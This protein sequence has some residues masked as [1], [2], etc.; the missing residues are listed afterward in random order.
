MKATKKSKSNTRKFKI[1]ISLIFATA[2]FGLIFISRKKHPE[3]EWFKFVLAKDMGV[4][5]AANIGKII[6]DAPAG[7][8]GFVTTRDKNFYFQDG[9]PIKFWGTNLCFSA[10]FPTKRQAIMLAK[11]LAFFGFNAVRLHHMDK[12]FSPDGIFKD[13]CP[14]CDNYQAKQTGVLDASQLDRLD[15]LIYQL[16]DRGIY[17]DLN[18]LVSRRFTLADGVKDAEKLEKAGKPVSM[19]D[20]TLIEL[21]KNYAKDLLTHY[22]PYTKLH[23]NEEPAIALVEITN[24]NS[25]FYFDQKLMPYYYIKEFDYF[26]ENFPKE[27]HESLKE[28]RGKFFVYLERKYFDEMIDFLRKECKVKVPIT[29]I[30]G[31]NQKENLLSMKNCSFFDVHSYWDHPQFPN[32][33][34]D[35]NDFQIH[36]KSM[37]LDKGLGIIDDLQRLQPNIN[38]PFTISE[39]DHCYPNQYAYEAMP[40][41]AYQAQKNNW[42]GL[43][44]FALSHDLSFW[45]KPD[46]I[47]YYF[48]IISNPQQLILASLGSLILNQDPDDIKARF[49]NAI[50][51]IEA[52]KI[53][54][55]VGFI[56]GQE[57]NFQGFSFS[58]DSDGA[59]FVYTTQDKPI[60]K[61]RKLVI[62]TLG[63]VKNTASGWENN[64]FNWGKPPTLLKKMN[65]KFSLD[66]KRKCRI[67]S[68]NERGTREEMLNTVR[69]GEKLYFSTK[70]TDSCWFEIV[71]F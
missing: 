41:M 31:Y 47:N 6:L 48:D 19:F 16:K 17:V 54:G 22:N 60:K 24:E 59:V 69:K 26:W 62:V 36:N 14:E 52:P 35:K 64:K 11:R 43:F 12:Y 40:L 61:A 30:G 20:Y 29:G 55:A 3:P 32:E 28:A 21:Q 50:L 23:Y 70:N 15:Y 45:P 18:L 71:E 68:L 51:R 8:H 67:Y 56:K 65:V 42:A 58:S 13:T 39:W 7:K 27:K 4:S 34:W 1:I 10:N 63:E 25:M 9:T 2:L 53:A 49:R 37:L 44:Q 66:S 33:P 57:I 38:K 5:S 46:K